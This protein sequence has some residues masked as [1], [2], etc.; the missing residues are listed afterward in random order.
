[1][2]GAGG[3]GGVGPMLGGYAGGDSSFSGM[4]GRSP[5]ETP[6]FSPYQ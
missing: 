2:G 1:M 5:W 6:P 3:A 4:F